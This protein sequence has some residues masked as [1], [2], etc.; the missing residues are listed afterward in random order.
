MRNL[1]KVLALVV[2]VAMFASMGFVASAAT[3]TDV[4]ANASYADAVNLLSNLGIITGYEDGTFRPDNTVT[5]AEAATM[6]VRMLGLADEVEAGETNFTDVD[7]DDWCSGY[8]NV[9]EANGI[10]NGMGDGTFNP[11]GEVT[12]GQIV[13]MIVC[14]LGYEPVALANGGYLGGGYLYA[15]SSQVTGF[16][17]GVAGTANAA[18]S[19]ATVARLIYN[20]LEVELMDQ[21]SFSTG[22]NGSTY[23]VLENKTILSEYLELEKVDGVVVNTYLS[24]AEFEAS[25]DKTIDL[26]VTKSYADEEVAMYE[27]GDELYGLIVEGTDAATLLGYTVTAYVGE[28]EEGDEAVFA[29]AAKAGKNS[30]TVLD[31]ELVKNMG[32][33]LDKNDEV[34]YDLGI[35]YYKSESAKSTTKAEIQNFV[36]I[37][38]G[39]VEGIAN[40]V[41]NGF[42]TGYTM[43]QAEVMA[44]VEAE[45]IDDITLIDNDN[46]GD[47]EFVVATIAN[48]ESFQE[49]VVDEID[50]EDDIW[51]FMGEDEGEIE[52]DYEDEDKLYTVVKD[53]KIADASAIVEGDVI[54]VL[55]DSTNVITVYVSS[56]VVEGTVDEV[57]DDIFTINGADYKVSSLSAETVGTIEAG[58][59]GLFYINASGKIAFV[60]TVN[61]I[62]GAD[63]VYVID[64]DLSEG[65][66]GDDEYLVKV[67]TAAGAVEVLTIKSKKVD[68]Y[69]EMTEETNEDGDTILVENVLEDV[70]DE[71][72]YAEL[73]DYEGL[74]RIDTTAAGEISVIYFPGSEDTF[75]ADDQY[76]AENTKEYNELRGTYGNID[77]TADVLVF[78]KDN[79]EE[80][81]EDAITVTTV[82]ALFDDESSYKFTAYGEE[83]EVPEVLVVEDAKTA[84][85]S[86]AP[87][88]VVTKV[89]DVVADDEDTIKIT[90]VVAGATV[91]VIVD[92]D[93]VNDV[94]VEKG[95]VILY[96]ESGDY[97]TDVEVLFAA[98]ADAPAGDVTVEEGSD[99]VTGFDDEAVSVHYGAIDDKTTKT[100]TIAGDKYYFADEVNVTVVDYTGSKMTVKAGSLSDVK[101]STKYT[102]TAFVKTVADVEDEVS[103]IVV[104]IE[105]AE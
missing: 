35:E 69:L 34:L 17:K 81:L 12:Y 41:V 66:F 97:V 92:P 30:V 55:D 43:G 95:N 27:A 93:E 87:V 29:I 4:A 14:A 16:T 49:F 38:S 56:V 40:F 70:T 23:E 13:K 100:V 73:V 3:Y 77:L 72:A 74:V 96:A 36:E 82:G 51:N 15:G 2:A 54:T 58:D 42:N 65:D 71:E 62:A 103:D 44:A 76:V 88:M 85:D 8:V 75:M 60:D 48:E 21:T 67:V 26:V 39:D 20:A 63:Y 68:V 94:A 22:I 80:D 104:F 83:E 37:K 53:G 19:R 31:T 18:A 6:I 105:L 59:E 11:N 32:E 7:A 24:N 1:K 64:A 61:S 47:F 84:L 9:A 46:D 10:I 99:I 5:R 45:S 33:I 86:E 78:H 91:S 79:T 52:I 90:G 98:T 57:D 28:N 101:T 50:N 89:A 25:E 102:K